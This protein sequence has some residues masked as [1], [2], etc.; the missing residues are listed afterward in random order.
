[1]SKKYKTIV[2]RFDDS[3][4]R[5][6][7][8]TNDKKN[9]NSLND[10]IDKITDAVSVG[11][12]IIES[13]KTLTS[14]FKE[15]TKVLNNIITQYKTT[16]TPT[17]LNS[18]ETTLNKVRKDRKAVQGNIWYQLTEYEIQRLQAENAQQAKEIQAY[19]ALD[20]YIQATKVLEKS[21][22]EIMEK[23]QKRKRPKPP[24][25][26][27]LRPNFTDA[28]FQIKALHDN[29][30]FMFVATLEQW[31]NLFSDNIKP[32]PVPIELKQGVTLAMLREFINGLINHKV[33]ARRGTLKT[34]ETANAF[35]FDNSKVTAKMLSD[36]QGTINTPF[37]SKSDK[38][39]SIFSGM[40]L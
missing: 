24:K 13:I 29:S 31:Q 35:S 27:T 1:M 19:K 4:K 38:I 32:F 36:A 5:I 37:Y 28:E 15:S 6:L 39:N 30:K 40:R 25:P 8:N 11:L 21:G 9:V 26:L 22:F 12:P 3:G 23:A 34:I 16:P 14:H 7:V 17:V 33:I 2:Y 20:K 18:L 10:I